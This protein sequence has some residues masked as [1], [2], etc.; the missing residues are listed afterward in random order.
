M[1]CLIIDKKSGWYCCLEGEEARPIDQITKDDIL[2]LLDLA[3][4]KDIDFE[5]DEITEENLA[6]P[7][8]RI[9]YANLYSKLLE[10]FENRDR[11]FDESVSVYKNA[12]EKYMDD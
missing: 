11:F 1:K 2:S 6:N 7:A 5:M 12:L 10:I 4:N 9:I 3:T 8:H